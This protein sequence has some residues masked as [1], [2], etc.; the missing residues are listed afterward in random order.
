MAI[1]KNNAELQTKINEALKKLKDNGQYD[2][3]YAKWFGDKK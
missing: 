3:I 1:N 2:Q